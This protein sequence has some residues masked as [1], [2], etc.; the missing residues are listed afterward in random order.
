MSNGRMTPS[1]TS[2]ATDQDHGNKRSN[3]TALPHQSEVMGGSKN[4]EFQPIRAIRGWNPPTG[5]RL[6]G[7]L[8][9]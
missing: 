6:F 1:L 4:P 9:G 3:R 2:S 8:G 7:G 5:D